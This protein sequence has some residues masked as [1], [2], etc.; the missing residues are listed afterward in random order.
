MKQSC[1]KLA[2]WRRASGRCA[3]ALSGSLLLASS[4]EAATAIN[5][6]TVQAVINAACNVSATTLNFGAY[7]PASGTALTGSSTVNVYCTA[8]TPYAAAL[9]IGSGGGSFTTRTI[10]SGSDTLNY[11]LYRDS[12]RT[13]VWGD[14]TGST[15][16]VAGTG[17]GPCALTRGSTCESAKACGA[18]LILWA[19]E[20]QCPVD[21]VEVKSL[22][23]E[24]AA[25]RKRLAKASPMLL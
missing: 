19:P 13:Q 16:T 25:H 14:G 3:A 20:T 10:A 24:G 23:V 5:T 1:N 4:V 8:G 11:N 21:G 12:A 15:F 6:F 7:D 18:L 9:N 22:R 2:R 17:S